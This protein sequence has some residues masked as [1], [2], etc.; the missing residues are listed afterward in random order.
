MKSLLFLALLV[1]LAVPAD[2]GGRRRAAA[3]SPAQS[4]VS[5]TFV[6]T[7]GSGSEAWMDAGT[8]SAAQTHSRQNANGHIVTRRSFAIRID[9][10][11]QIGTA[12]LRA[13]LETTDHNSVVRI[14]G[15]SLS[16]VPVVIDPQARIG[17]A[18]P[19]ALEIEIP[20]SAPEGTFASAV[21]WEVVTQ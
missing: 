14:D 9:A 19:H 15:I 1:T 5:I 12:M 16:T 13:F 3:A 7:T 21:R 20:A 17:A 18:V 6:G 2:A 4:D 11:G 8:L 10:P